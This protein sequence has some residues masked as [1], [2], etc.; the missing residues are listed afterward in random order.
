MLLHVGL[1]QHTRADQIEKT[2]GAAQVEFE[3]EGRTPQL[4]INVKRDVLRRYNLQAAEVN[5]RDN[6]TKA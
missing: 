3:T 2:P 5:T 6:R 4:Q 1:I